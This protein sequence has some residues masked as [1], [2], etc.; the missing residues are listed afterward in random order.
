MSTEQTS[1]SEDRATPSSPTPTH[2]TVA[3]PL[4]SRARRRL[5]RLIWASLIAVALIFGV[6][7][8]WSMPSG[9]E[10]S[11]AKLEEATSRLEQTNAHLSPAS[12]PCPWCGRVTYVVR[13]AHQIDSITWAVA[14]GDTVQ[15]TTAR[16]KSWSRAIRRGEPGDFL[17][18]SAQNA[19]RG[20][21]VCEIWL[22]DAVFPR[23][24]LVKRSRS[25]GQFAICTASGTV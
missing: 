8:L 16:W 14:G 10:R 11:L 1:Y 12:G 7:V 4:L 9:V 25:L 24:V 15:D 21:I 6:V 18:V 17:Y 13:A 20:K 19:G 2:E 5:R 23:S 3:D 22:G